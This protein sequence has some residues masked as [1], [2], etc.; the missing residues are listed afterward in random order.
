V[1]SAILATAAV[2]VGFIPV[3]PAHA[4]TG[5]VAIAFSRTTGHAAW[6]G[7]PGATQESAEQAA[8]SQCG[9]PDCFVLASDPNCVSYAFDG[10]GH[11]HGVTGATEQDVMAQLWGQYRAWDQIVRC[12]WNIK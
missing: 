9:A 10:T 5:W 6:K 4:D 2:I 8:L 7:G 12:Y 11:I 1:K 3:A